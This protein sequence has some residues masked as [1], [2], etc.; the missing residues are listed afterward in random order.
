[1]SN[2]TDEVVDALEPVLNEVEG[3]DE[4]IETLTD[5]LEKPGSRDS[6]QVQGEEF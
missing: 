2:E 5:I 3:R 4:E 6:K 1:L